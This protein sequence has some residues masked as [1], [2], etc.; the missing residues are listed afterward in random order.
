MHIYSST[1]VL[2]YVYICT[3]KNT[4]RFYIGAR[5]AKN[6]KLPSHL[7]FPNY[8][9]SSPR[10]KENFKDYSWYIVAEFYN[11]SDAY[12]FEQQLIHQEWDN[13]LLM[14]ESCF[15]K[16]KQF[17]CTELSET[18]KQSISKAQSGKII[19]EYTKEKLRTARVKQITTDATREKISK[20]LIGNSR[21]K[22]PRS[23]ETKQKIKDSLA[24]T[25]LSTPKVLGMLGK[26]HSE[27]TRAKMRAS[28]MIRKNKNN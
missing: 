6:L 16:K 5:Y 21:S 25:Y 7:D 17:R 4:R 22:K 20:S 12:D 27:E 18:H 9:T 3:H 14:N 26:Q 2:P 1:K 8:K 11:S 13:S 24:N 19:S 15:Y 28:H 10:I 23:A